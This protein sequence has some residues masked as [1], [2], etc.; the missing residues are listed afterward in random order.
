MLYYKN[1][2]IFQLG[3]WE[4]CSAIQFLPEEK[5]YVKREIIC[6]HLMCLWEPPV[7]AEWSKALSQIAPP[8]RLKVVLFLKNQGAFVQFYFQYKSF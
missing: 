7:A 3:V 2:T 8:K 4:W 1:I 5:N 6:V